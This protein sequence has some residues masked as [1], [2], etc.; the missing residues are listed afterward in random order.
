[1]KEYVHPD[2]FK[3]WQETGDKMGFSYTA[4][5]PLVRSSYKAGESISATHPRKFC[6]LKKKIMRLTFKKKIFLRNKIFGIRYSSV[7]FVIAW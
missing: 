4:S 6:G 7:E 1:M 5:G 2:K 3:Y